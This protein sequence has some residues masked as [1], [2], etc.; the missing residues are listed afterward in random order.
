MLQLLVLEYSLVDSLRKNNGNEIMFS[1]GT[2][3]SCYR[4][5]RVYFSSHISNRLV[6]GWANSLVQGPHSKIHNLIGPH[7]ILTQIINI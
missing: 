7:S 4:L 1:W 6:Q 5:D 2:E 3:N